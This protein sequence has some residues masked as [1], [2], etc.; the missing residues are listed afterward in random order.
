MTCKPEML[1]ELLKDCKTPKDVESLYSQMLQRVINRSLEAEMDV[2]LG[3]ERHTKADAESP[4]ANRR[5]GA[6]IKTVKGEFGRP[7]SAS[8]ITPWG[9]SRLLHAARRGG[10]GS[11]RSRTSDS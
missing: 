10:S 7:P 8:A 2:R 9:S 5:N 1:D 11:E 4:R 3:Y 6:S